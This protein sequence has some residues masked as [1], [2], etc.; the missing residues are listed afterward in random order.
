[1]TTLLEYFFINYEDV[2][3]LICSYF[4]PKDLQNSLTVIESLVSKKEPHKYRA[5]LIEH[6]LKNVL[7]EDMTDYGVD[8]L[9]DNKIHLNDEYILMVDIYIKNKYKPSI[10]QSMHNYIENCI[11][12]RLGIVELIYKYLE[13]NYIIQD[14]FNNLYRWLLLSFAQHIT[15]YTHITKFALFEK[16][17]FVFNF[18]DCSFND[19]HMIMNYCCNKFELSTHYLYTNYFKSKIN[20]INLFLVYRK[21]FEPTHFI[22]LQYLYKLILPSIVSNISFNIDKSCF[23]NSN[24]IIKYDIVKEIKKMAKNIL[25]YPFIQLFTNINRHY[26][27]SNRTIIIWLIINYAMNYMYL[28]KLKHID[29]FDTL[30]KY[31]YRL[32]LGWNIQQL[33][34]E[35]VITLIKYTLYHQFI[36]DSNIDENYDMW[37]CKQCTYLNNIIMPFCEICNKNIFY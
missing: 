8:M 11:N 13:T 25:E 7:T 5:F 36:I 1:M 16:C 23:I 20:P 2:S 19:F 18:E 22:D 35:N 12:G 34:S 9:I 32:E 4:D 24:G 33:L 15:E 30:N 21:E 3:R 26:A 17:K 31:R 14:K 6:Y 29:I 37:E 27:T 28:D 10:G